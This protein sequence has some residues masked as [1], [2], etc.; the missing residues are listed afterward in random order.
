MERTIRVYPD[1]NRWAARWNDAK[2][3][4]RTFNTQAEA[5]AFAHRLARQYQAIVELHGRDGELRQRTKVA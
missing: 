1:T 2:R 5:Y 4:S 3:A